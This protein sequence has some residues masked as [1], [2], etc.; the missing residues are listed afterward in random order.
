VYSGP[1]SA[2][3]NLGSQSSFNPATR[4]RL[5][6]DMVMFIMSA[7]SSFSQVASIRRISVVPTFSLSTR[8][9]LGEVS[10]LMLTTMTDGW[11]PK[12]TSESDMALRVDR[13]IVLGKECKDW[14]RFLQRMMSPATS[15]E[16]ICKGNVRKRSTRPRSC[17]AI[18]RVMY[19]TLL[20]DYI[21]EFF[22][23]YWSHYILEDKSLEIKITLKL[24]A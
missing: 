6:G 18:V 9:M 14:L 19:V 3:P 23:F 24:A 10:E 4:Q 20:P 13:L 12:S 17:Q 11:V 22:L 1:C 2:F 7:S 15:V 16:G 5:F 8:N 21:R